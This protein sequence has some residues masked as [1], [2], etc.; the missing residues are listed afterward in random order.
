[1]I[2]AEELLQPISEE[3]PCGEDLSYDVAF[4]ELET[5]TRGKPETQFSPAEPPDWKHVQAKCL[6]LFARS[7][8]LR[9]A[10]TLTLA[11]LEL[12]ELPG[13]RQGLAVMKGLLNDHWSTVYPQ[14]DPADDN[15]PLHRMNIVASLATAVGTFGD[16]FQVLERLRRIP[17]CNSVRMGRYSLLDILRVEAGVQTS[18]DK[19]DL[20]MAQIDAAFRS[21]D[22]RELA[23]TYQEL[24]SCLAIVHEI[25]ESITN[26]VGASRAPDLGL[27]P[28]ELLAMQKRIVPYLPSE[29]VLRPVE[30][31]APVGTESAENLQ[32]GSATGEIRSREDVLKILFK[33]C[34]YYDR[35]EPSS[36]VPLML[37]RAARLAKMDF[38]GIMNDLSPDAI[39]QIRTI[40]GEKEAE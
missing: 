26:R 20:T 23:A 10:L 8:D 15:D 31:S 36:P 14:L 7:K 21:T 40:T 28:G 18:G 19:Q 17:L 11:L 12:E 9:I 22:P 27:L 5:M 30:E 1:M 24:S 39:S 37:K 6:E 34:E 35:C 3:S 32:M 38:M 4:Q 29:A 25:D 2:V 13:F 33:I 16:P